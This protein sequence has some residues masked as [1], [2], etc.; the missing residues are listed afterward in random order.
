MR[1]MFN[2]EKTIYRWSVILLKRNGRDYNMLPV[3][4]TNQELAIRQLWEKTTDESWVLTETPFHDWTMRK[5]SDDDRCLAE[6]RVFKS[7]YQENV[8]ALSRLMSV[9]NKGI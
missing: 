7:P 4:A 5:Y 6:I 1:K 3:Y 9:I 8:P 2:I